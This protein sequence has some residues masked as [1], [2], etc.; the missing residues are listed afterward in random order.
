MRICRKEPICMHLAQFS[1]TAPDGTPQTRNIFP[2]PRIPESIQT[3]RASLEIDLHIHSR[4]SPDSRSRVENIV[5]RAIQLGLGA[6]AVTDHDTWEGAKAAARAAP[7]SLLIVPGAELKTEKGDLL[8]LFVEEV[9][10][11]DYPGI[12]DEVKSAGGISIVPHPS[13][14]SRMTS[15][16]IAMADAVEVYNSTLSERLNSRSLRYAADLKLPGIG[17]S[18]AH[19]I[20]EIGNGRTTVPDCQSLED[21]RRSLLQSPVV[22]RKVRSNP[23]LHR[24]NEVVMFGLKGLWKRL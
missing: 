16:A 3:G 19:M 17:S 21:L 13:A 10:D 4:Y 7:E 9:R 23:V 24:A 11:K 1:R 14:S 2:R 15:Q 12:I 22:S 6:I 8:A 20:M 5:R 18:D